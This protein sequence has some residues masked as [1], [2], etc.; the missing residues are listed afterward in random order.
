[1]NC[2][3]KQPVFSSEKQT[4]I[5]L[6]KMKYLFSVWSYLDIQPK[7]T[8]MCLMKGFLVS[9][10][11]PVFRQ[12]HHFSTQHLAEWLQNQMLLYAARR[13]YNSK[14]QICSLCTQITDKECNRVQIQCIERKYQ[15]SS[16][17]SPITFWF[18]TLTYNFTSSS[19]SNWSISQDVS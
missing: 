3:N 5:H 6:V 12:W 7:I 18:A 16:L 13:H 9:D 10:F 11:L 1:M 8:A 17:A 15:N 4:F 14:Y 2:G 19:Y